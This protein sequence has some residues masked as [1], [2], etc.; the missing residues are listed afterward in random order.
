MK[1]FNL[2]TALT[3]SLVSIPF[4]PAIKQ[5]A[6]IKCEC[7]PGLVIRPSW[8]PNN[9]FS[10][11]ENS[12]CAYRVCTGGKHSS[13]SGKKAPSLSG[14]EYR[15]LY[16]Q[17]QKLPA[18][19]KR[20]Q[21]NKILSAL[22]QNCGRN[23]HPKSKCR[24][25]VRRMRRQYSDFRLIYIAIYDGYYREWGRVAHPYLTNHARGCG[26]MLTKRII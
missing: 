21:A 23:G 3:I 5:A 13:G 17:A 4:A 19:T 11:Y 20:V 10:S 16:D 1:I 12:S 6:G 8:D 24:C 26:I 22:Y 14:K 7:R 18:K 9:K 2:A 25:F 15:A